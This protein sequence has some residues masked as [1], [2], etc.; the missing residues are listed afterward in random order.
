MKMK[1]SLILRRLE[2]LWHIVALALLAGAFVP[3]WRSQVLGDIEMREGDAILRMVLLISFA[4]VGLLLWHFQSALRVARRNWFIWLPVGL[5]FLSALWSEVPELT[6]R[7]SVA[8]LLATLYGL[9]LS[10]RFSPTIVLRLVG[11]AMAVIV[12]ASVVSISMGAQWAVMQYLHPGSWQGVMLHKNSLGKIC[13]V[14]MIFAWPLAQAAVKLEKLFW[15]GIAGMAIY[16]VIGSNSATAMVVTVLLIIVGSVIKLVQRWSNRAKRWLAL[17]L[18]ASGLLIGVLAFVW[19]EEIVYLLGRDLSL[20]GR[21]P[22]WLALWPVLWQ[23]PLLGYGFGA[24]WDSPLAE[25]VAQL[26]NWQAVHAHNG[27][28]ELWLDLGI[29]GLFMISV[30]LFSILRK[31]WKIFW[32][33][34]IHPIF[35]IGFLSVAYTV[36][37]SVVEVVL[38]K[39]GLGGVWFWIILSYVYFAL[40]SVEIHGVQRNEETNPR[41]LEPAFHS[42]SDVYLRSSCWIDP[43]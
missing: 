26:A 31:T 5:A 18:A 27:I 25:N 13:V 3:L 6:I 19:I 10:V 28:L 9:L 32:L 43:I 38:F 12:I 20:T 36:L 42:N 37:Y 30:I 24:F 8:V 7:R 34:N 22:L 35:Y 14:A 11:L 17:L 4:G 29:L 1:F 15:I 39:P 21:V 33:S 41:V 16:L 23:R 2:Y 40:A